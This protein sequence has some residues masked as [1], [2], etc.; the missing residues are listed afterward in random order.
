MKVT[1]CDAAG[2]K[3]QIVMEITLGNVKGCD[4]NPDPA[5]C[6]GRWER[7]WIMSSFIS[8]LVIAVT[9]ATGATYHIALMLALA[10]MII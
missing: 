8:G 1:A 6:C 7:G 10:A 3:R 5:R 9:I 2:L 4:G